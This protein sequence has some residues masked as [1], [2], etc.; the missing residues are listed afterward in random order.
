[1][2]QALW[3]LSGDLPLLTPIVAAGLRSRQSRALSAA[4]PAAGMGE[5]VTDAVMGEGVSKAKRSSAAST[6]GKAVAEP[7]AP[8]AG[9]EPAEPETRPVPVIG[10][11]SVIGGVGVAG[12]HTAIVRIEVEAW[13]AGIW[14]GMRLRS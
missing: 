6:V 9:V 11:I 13:I 1:M 10:P 3:R 4:E 5:A 8:L 7:A 12:R 2:R 14:G